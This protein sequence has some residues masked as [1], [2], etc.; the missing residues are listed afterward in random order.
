MTESFDRDWLDLREPFDALARNE[1]LAD[2][3][4]AVLP[5]RPRLLDLG[6]G[7]GALLRW[8]APRIGRA[9]SWTLVDADRL[10]LEAAFETIADRAEQV[11][12]TVTVPNRRTLLVHAPGG[13]W[14][15]ET[16]VA[17]LA[18]APQ[19]LPLA[20]TDA[21]VCSALCDLVSRNWL[22]RLAASLRVPFYAALNVDG[23]DRW[24]PPHPADAA[25]AGAFRRDQGRD[26]GFRG[27]ALGPHAAAA[28]AA[29]FAARGFTV[30][31]ARSDWQARQR[32]V[33]HPLLRDHA[34]H[35]LTKLALG[36]AEA[37]RAG[38]PRGHAR[39]EAWLDARLDQIAL[40][41]LGVRIGHRDVLALPGGRG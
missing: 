27:A 5:A 16:L 36:H 35:F 8:L 12:Y 41:N 22:E 9:Q 32:G 14:R 33:M 39:R 31:T 15:V 2:A 18:A 13:A 11:G 37:A 38:T 3:L 7:T 21:V 30:Q 17:D 34:G 19:G 6:A 4:I 40:G 1:A 26:K 24:Q 23:R 28:I 10:L 29:V 25:M 20:N